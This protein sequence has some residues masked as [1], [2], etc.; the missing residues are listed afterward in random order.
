MQKLVT[1]VPGSY[2]YARLRLFELAGSEALAF[3]TAIA[4]VMVYF[5]CYK[6][7]SEQ[8][9]LVSRKVT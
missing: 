9:H 2:R 6:H 8:R 3:L 5:A 7:R 1:E 4:K